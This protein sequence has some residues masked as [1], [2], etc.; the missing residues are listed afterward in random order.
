[1]KTIRKAKNAFIYTIDGQKYYDLSSNTNIIGHSHRLLT[2]LPKN[3]LS[4]AWNIR[5]TSIYHNRFLRLIHSCF[6]DDW[7]VRCASSLTDLWL[8]MVNAGIKPHFCGTD[9]LSNLEAHSVKIPHSEQGI[10][11]IETADDYINNRSVIP[12]KND[13]LNGWWYPELDMPIG[14]A[15]TVILPE[16]FSGFTPTVFVLV[17]KELEQDYSFLDSIE[18]V[19]SFTLISAVNLYHTIRNQQNRGFNRLRLDGTIALQRGRLFR[20]NGETANYASRLAEAHVIINPEPPYYCYLP[21]NLEHYQI[22]YLYK[23]FCGLR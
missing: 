23:V 5:G 8:R 10:N 22:K 12:T 16:L 7:T 17:R 4:T 19:P 11:I 6:G 15:K 21:I 9:T 14:N 2:T 13:I 18:T 3:A 20:L 1:M